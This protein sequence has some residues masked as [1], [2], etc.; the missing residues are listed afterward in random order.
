VKKSK[1]LHVSIQLEAL[2]RVLSYSCAP[3]KRR[4]LLDQLPHKKTA[5]DHKYLMENLKITTQM[6]LRKMKMQ[7]K[8]VACWLAPLK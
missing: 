6:E 1:L 2:R 5:L 7:K 4:N 3:A 8:K